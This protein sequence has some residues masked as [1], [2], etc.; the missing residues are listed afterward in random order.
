MR[1]VPRKM[2]TRDQVKALMSDSKV[3]D[4]IIDMLDELV[5][6]TEIPACPPFVPKEICEKLK[7]GKA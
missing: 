3:Q 7:T 2:P 1:G 4:R 5:T 6:M